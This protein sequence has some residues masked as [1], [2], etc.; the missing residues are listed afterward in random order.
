MFSTMQEFSSSS[1]I[2][3][4]AISDGFDGGGRVEVET[5]NKFCYKKFELVSATFFTRSCAVDN[6][7][8]H[9]YNNELK[10]P[11]S[12]IEIFVNIPGLPVLESSDLPSF[13]YFHGCA[14]YTVDLHILLTLCI[15][16]NLATTIIRTASVLQKIIEC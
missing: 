8:C 9:V 3:L 6:I 10:L 11:I 16:E 7:Y 5:Q 4:E 12:D 15:F 14:Y 13:V 1:N 2:S